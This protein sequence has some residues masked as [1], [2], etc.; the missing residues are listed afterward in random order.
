MHKKISIIIPAYNTADVIYRT[1]TS[2]EQQTY[3]DYKIFFVKKYLFN[4][5]YR[6]NLM[7]NKKW[8]KKDYFHD[9][10][11]LEDICNYVKNNYLNECIKSI[12]KHKNYI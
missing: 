3:P 11:S 4:Y 1:L 2:V 8:N 10:T 9:A 5:Y 7:T 12:I 6:K